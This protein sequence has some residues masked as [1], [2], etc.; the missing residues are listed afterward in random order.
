MVPLREYIPGQHW[1]PDDDRGTG[2][3][4]FD[5]WDRFLECSIRA[6][7]R[8]EHEDCQDLDTPPKMNVE[9]DFEEFIEY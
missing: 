5:H 1:F 7:G 8:R 6:R 4:G 9:H 2:D 3:R